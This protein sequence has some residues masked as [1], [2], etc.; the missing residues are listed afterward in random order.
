MEVPAGIYRYANPGILLDSHQYRTRIIPDSLC[1][2]HTNF[3][4]IFMVN[5]VFLICS[6][7]AF[8]SLTGIIGILL[9]IALGKIEV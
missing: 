1:S 8:V 3:R 5:I 4:G 9:G 7:L 6:V 2:V